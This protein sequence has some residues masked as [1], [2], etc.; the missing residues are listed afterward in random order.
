MQDAGT[1]V[2][3]RTLVAT[4]LANGSS[5]IVWRLE[6]RLAHSMPPVAT[7]SLAEWQTF[8]LTVRVL[9]PKDDVRRRMTG[10]IS[11]DVSDAS[12]MPVYQQLYRSLK[13]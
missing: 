9:L 6:N 2:R 11:T 3:S 5:S 12:G 1:I 13:L 8:P 10:D 4:A 7:G